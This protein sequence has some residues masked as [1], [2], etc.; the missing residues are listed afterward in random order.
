MNEIPL[1][2][3]LEAQGERNRFGGDFFFTKG[4]QK[5][6]QEYRKRKKNMGVGEE[7]VWK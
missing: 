7:G 2:G 3:N 4:R 6:L 5:C 1:P